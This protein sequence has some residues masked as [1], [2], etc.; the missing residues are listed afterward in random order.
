MNEA[1]AVNAKM[2]QEE[3]DQQNELSKRRQAVVAA[4]E[5][6]KT[7]PDT[8]KIKL[9]EGEIA[10][11]RKLMIAN[12]DPKSVQDQESHID[13]LT[14]MIIGIREK[15][16][17]GTS[18]SSTSTGTAPRPAATPR[19]APPVAPAGNRKGPPAAGEVRD[20]WRYKGGSPSN[21]SSW[22]RV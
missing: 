6:E 13:A 14:G 10:T 1:Q 2:R 15:S 20:G 8:E 18:P 11:R 16:R 4:A 17:R 22:E 5:A 21:K 19:V 3:I 7:S 12:P 9:M